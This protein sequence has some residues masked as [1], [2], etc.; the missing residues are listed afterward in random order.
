MPNHLRFRISPETTIATGTTV[1]GPDEIIRGGA[2]EMVAGRRPQPEE[3]DEYE[4]ILGDAMAG[5]A[6]LFAREDYVEGARR[7]VDPSLKASTPVLEYDKGAWRR[8][9]EICHMAA[10]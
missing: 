5:D 6:A 4:R 1:M 7:I 10:G 9:R 2:V 3:M 8:T